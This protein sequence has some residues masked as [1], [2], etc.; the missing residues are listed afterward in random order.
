M[1][2]LMFETIFLQYL[3]ILENLDNSSGWLLNNLLISNYFKKT[4]FIA[5]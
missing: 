4:F 3:I 2:F 5:Y 1:V